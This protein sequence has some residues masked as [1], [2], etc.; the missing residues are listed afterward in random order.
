VPSHRGAYRGRERRSHST[1]RGGH[2]YSPYHR[3]QRRA[4]G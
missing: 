3:G 1:P 4:D 2:R